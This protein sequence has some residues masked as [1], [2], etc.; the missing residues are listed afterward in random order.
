M[1]RQRLGDSVG[2]ACEPRHATWFIEVADACL[3]KHRAARVIAD[4]TVVPAG[5][6]PGG[7]AGLRYRRLHGSPRMYYSSYEP[8][9]LKSLADAILCDRKALV[10]SWCIFDNSASGAATTD[11]I[12]LK[13]L[14]EVF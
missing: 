6:R 9:R 2:T 12:S 3:A 11:A 8:P 14:L 1:L 5:E 10:P 7:W 4:P 13:S